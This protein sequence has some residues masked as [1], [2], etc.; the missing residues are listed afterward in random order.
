MVGNGTSW[1]ILRERKLPSPP[2]KSE[3]ERHPPRVPLPRYDT[4]SSNSHQGLKKNYFRFYVP[5]PLVW[6]VASIEPH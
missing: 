6:G 1:K 3:K 2:L 5:N 4:Y